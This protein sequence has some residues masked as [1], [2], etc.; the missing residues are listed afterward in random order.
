MAE[1]S[2]FMTTVKDL[3][4][5]CDDEL[6]LAGVVLVLVNKACPTLYAF[7]LFMSV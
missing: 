1:R 2:V 7:S 5:W 6:S 3:L 4:C